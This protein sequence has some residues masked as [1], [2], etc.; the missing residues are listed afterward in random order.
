M[1]IIAQQGLENIVDK[2]TAS[3]LERIMAEE[4]KV[5]Q[6]YEALTAKEKLAWNA[7]TTT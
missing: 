5:K 2:S 7:P 3:R 6:W 1:L 4:E